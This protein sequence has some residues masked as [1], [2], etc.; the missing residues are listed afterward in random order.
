MP[1]DHKKAREPKADYANGR[2]LP[3]LSCAFRDEDLGGV[4]ALGTERGW[5][6]FRI[7][8]TGYIRDISP[9]KKGRHPYF[10]PGGGKFDAE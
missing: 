10:T 8:P 1:S 4:W 5:F 2:D 9:V 7:T 3:K 6:E